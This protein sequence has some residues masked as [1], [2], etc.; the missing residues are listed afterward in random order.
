[1]AKDP[2]DRP[3]SAD[4]LRRSLGTMSLPAA[5]DV[6]D[7]PTQPL[8]PV[9]ATDILPVVPPPLPPRRPPRSSS[10]LLWI[11]GLVAR[12][13]RAAGP[14]RDLRRSRPRG[15]GSDPGRASV[16]LAGVV[17]VSPTPIAAIAD[18]DAPATGSVERCDGRADRS[19][20]GTGVIG[21]RR[22]AS[23]QGSSTRCGRHRPRA[24]RGRR[25]E[26]HGLARQAAGQ[27]GQR[28]GARGDLLRGCA[29]P[30]TRRSKSSPRPS[31]WTGLTR[32]RRPATVRG[33]SAKPGSSIDREEVC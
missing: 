20:P 18:S 6:G 32:E 23:R 29:A 10:A 2:A 16:P 9:A 13:H 33:A 19:G 3:E 22:R 30:R 28:P 12:D 25:R 14:Q 17:A 11:V 27:G 7:V 15:Q 26:G 31:S 24:Q 21:S 1:M 4:A 8:T 5:S